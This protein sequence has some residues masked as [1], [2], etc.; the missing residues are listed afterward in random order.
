[1]MGAAE[2]GVLAGVV[3][4]DGGLAAL[5]GGREEVGKRERERER[6]GKRLEEEKEEKEKPDFRKKKN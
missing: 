5:F 1:M 2:Q 3:H 4:D 6:E